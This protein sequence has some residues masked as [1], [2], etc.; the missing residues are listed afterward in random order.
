MRGVSADDRI[1]ELRTQR[2]HGYGLSRPWY[3]DEGVFAA[4]IDSIW[5]VSW[6]VV[7]HSEEIRSGGDRLAVELG[8]DPIVVVRQKDGGLRAFH[9][10]CRHRGSVIV[11]EERSHDTLL[12]C[13]YHRWSYGLDGALRGCPGADEGIDRGRLRL[14]DV[15]AAEVS[16]FVLVSLAKTPVDLEPLRR[17]LLGQPES[18][19]LAGAKVAATIEYEIAANWKLVWENNRECLHCASNHPQYVRANYD[20][21]RPGDTVPG[22]LYEFPD[23][24]GTQWWSVNR[25]PMRPPFVTES[26]DGSPVAPPFPSA[27]GGHPETLRVRVLP[28]FWAHVS[29]DH[30]VTTR[31]QPLG[32]GTTRAKVTW[33][34]R[35]DAVEGR[36]Y[37]LE[38]LLPF[39]RLTSEQDWLICE[40]QQRG[41]RSSAYVA[42]PLSSGLECNVMNFHAWYEGRLVAP[43][44]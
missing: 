5:R 40:R 28:N 22:G 19:S 26:L 8:G 23:P 33:L 25:T 20:H 3:L 42:G 38:A 32:P 39:W 44:H 18:D 35:P 9:N 17:A 10:V 36:D 41:V 43:A 29:S 34:V 6:C 7:G 14:H 13:P 12:V 24:S 15:A 30:A 4:E 27:A 2:L 11:T 21:A 1:G 37:D 16:G 31:L